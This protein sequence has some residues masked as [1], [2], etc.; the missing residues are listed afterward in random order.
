MKKILKI[1]GI[2]IAVVLGALLILPS[3]FKDKVKDVLVSEVSSMLNAT[4]YLEDFSLGFF[5]NFP[6]ATLSVENFGI[7]GVA[8]FEN[9]TLVNVEDLNVVI[10]L[11]SLFKESYEINK[12][13]LINPSAK[14]IVNADSLA[15]WD[16]MK[17]TEPEEEVEDTTASS[18]IKLGLDELVVRN[19]CASYNSV[20]DSMSASVEGIDLDLEGDVALDLETLVNIDDLQLLIDKV[21]YSDY[22]SGDMSAALDNVNLKFGGTVSDRISRMNLALDVDST[23]FNMGGVPYL[24]KAR[25]SSDI[26]MVA[27]LD[28]NKYSFG[29]NRVSL[30]EISAKFEGFVHLVDSATTDMDLKVITPSIDFKQILSLIPVIYAKDFESLQT[31]GEVSLSAMAKGRLKGDSV[32]NLDAQLNIVD[33]MFKYPDLPGA[34]KNINI[35]ANVKNPGGN[36]DLTEVQVPNLSFIM[37]ESPFALTFGLKN[38]ISDPDFNATANGTINLANVSKVVKL[39][40]MDLQGIF[41]AALKAGGKMSYIDQNRYELFNIDGSLKLADFILKT[42]SLD[43]DVEVNNA[44]LGF[45]SENVNLNANLALGKSDLSL[46]GKLQHFIQFVTRGETIKGSLAVQSK[47]IDVNQ[48]LGTSE[49]EGEPVS[50]ETETPAAESSSS[51]TLPDNINFALDMAIDSIYYGNV[52]LASVKGLV[53]LKDAVANIRTFSANTMGG[54]LGVTGKYDTQDTLN[55]KID[56]SLD[57][58]DMVINEVFSTVETAKKIVPLFSDAEGNFSLS[59]DLKSNMDATLTPILETVNAKG[60]FNSKDISL[61]NVEAF[62]AL[63]EKTGM[64]LFQKPNLKNLSIAFEIKDGRLHIDPFETLIS[65]TKLNVSGSSG[66]DQTLDYVAKIQLP[67]NVSKVVDLIF[68][69]KIGGTFS[70][71]KISFGASSIKEQVKEKVTEVVDKAKEAAIAAAKEQKEKLVAAAQ[72]QREKLVATAQES[73]DKLVAKA[74]A[75]RDKNVANA[76]N[77]IAKAAAQKAGDALVKKTKEQA[78]KMVSDANKSGDK[79]VSDAEKSGNALIEKASA[80]K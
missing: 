57:V 52:K 33:A 17:P 37:M 27:D 72:A 23:S 10:N 31:S 73:A 25:I 14:I 80:G 11:A 56:V 70:K 19:L 1:C 16:I 49:E 9:D 59:M 50:D 12:I 60:S 78:D 71:P 2:I 22:S 29:E 58:N 42:Q 74:E 77:P 76:K 41:T 8:P 18:P 28:S 15:N 38:P 3:L 39:E 66:L 64:D 54:S 46:N 48:L 7:V 45:S 44:D 55:P 30:N 6:H 69:M 67:E 5:S 34:M 53:D 51:V 36:V 43:Y 79:L 32:P 68:D 4:L 47:K 75:E 40:D 35:T 21:S 63:A 26:K 61:K 62:S 20:P 13:E 24:S 65:M